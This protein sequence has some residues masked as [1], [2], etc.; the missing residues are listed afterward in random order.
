MARMNLSL[1]DELYEQLAAAVPQG[2][3]SQ[4]VAAAIRDLLIR[5]A[6]VAATRTS[7]GTWTRD[8]SEDPTARLRQSREGWGRRL[9]RQP[10]FE[11]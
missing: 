6:Q 11:S 2:K 1:E 3:R 5:R 9:D 7:A 4:F 8:E 10:S